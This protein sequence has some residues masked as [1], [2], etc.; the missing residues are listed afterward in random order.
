MKVI[1]LFIFIMYWDSNIKAQNSFKDFINLF[2][3]YQWEDLPEDV[4]NLK[5]EI[6]IDI[7]KANMF[8][9]GKHASIAIKTSTYT[10]LRNAPHYMNMD[11]SFDKGDEGMFDKTTVCGD[12]LAI[13]I[14]QP[15][16]RVHINSDIELLLLFYRYWDPEL[17]WVEFYE[18]YTYRITDEQLLSSLCLLN[19]MK[20]KLCI[21]F[22]QPDRFINIYTTRFYLKKVTNDEF[23]EAKT[24]DKISY[25]LRDDGYFQQTE[26]FN[27]EKSGILFWAK[28]SDSEGWANIREKP[29]LK[30]SILY[31]AINEH[32]ILLEKID[33][34]IWFK[35]IYYNN[36]K[37]EYHGGFIH[38]SRIVKNSPR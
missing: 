28:V 20:D 19:N 15:L 8:M 18:A 30:S 5:K 3:E 11:G 24:I 37:Q 23:E 35:V 29:I 17:G 33:S 16:G 6:R 1:Y 10:Y 22:K 21:S 4:R 2:P 27:A 34:S 31:K 12:S 9:W 32:F 26:E 36:S 13:S 38:S 7:D 14:L 25:R